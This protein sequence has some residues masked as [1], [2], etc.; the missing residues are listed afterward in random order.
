V[1]VR[2]VSD[3]FNAVIPHPMKESMKAKILTFVLATVFFNVSAQ[4]QTQGGGWYGELG[5]TA[6][7]M[8][9]DYPGG[10]DTVTPSLARFV[11]GKELGSNYAV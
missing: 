4:A 9:N 5:Y 6:M 8:K 10:S 1:V 3:A 2:N 11:V 7:S